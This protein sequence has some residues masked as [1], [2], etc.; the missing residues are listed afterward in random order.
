M[1]LSF[2]VVSFVYLL[3]YVSYSW[4]IRILSH[5]SQRQE[6]TEN[7]N[8]GMLLCWLKTKRKKSFLLQTLPLIPKINL[9]EHTLRLTNI[10]LTTYL[11]TLK[12]HLTTLHLYEC[13]IAKTLEFENIKCTINLIQS[14]EAATV[15]IKKQEKKEVRLILR[16]QARPMN[17]NFFMW[18][19][20]Y[21]N[22]YEKERWSV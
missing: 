6:L 2:W 4:P 21:E 20:W 9:I 22:Q 15:D 3:F 12:T 11:R 13:Q 19:H 5:R 18:R 7:L 8:N 10:F 16:G 1:V 17:T 14:D